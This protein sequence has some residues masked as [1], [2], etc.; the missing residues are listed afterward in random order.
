MLSEKEKIG[1]YTEDYIYKAYRGHYNPILT[2]IQSIFEGHKNEIETLIKNY[3]EW[4]RTNESGLESIAP[5]PDE[6]NSELGSSFCEIDNDSVKQNQIFSDLYNKL[7]L[8]YSG[9]KEATSYKFIG[10]VCDQDCIYYD[11][12][13]K[14]RCTEDH[15]EQAIKIYQ[16]FLDEYYPNLSEPDRI[17]TLNNILE[18]GVGTYN[19]HYDGGAREI[20]LSASIQGVSRTIAHA[21]YTSGLTGI[22]I[23]RPFVENGTF[24]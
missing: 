1:P 12:L 18:K 10:F 21:I 22:N 15:A 16:D 11:M 7:K 6:D 23:I 20:S 9:K 14:N 3:E 17:T 13:D 2:G 4:E 19:R 5:A 24:P 8:I